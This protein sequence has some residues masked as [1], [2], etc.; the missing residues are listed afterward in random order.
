MDYR[1]LGRTG[2]EVSPLCLGTMMFGA[3]GNTD[4]DDSIRVIH[5]ALDAGINFIDCA[6]V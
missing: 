3:W 4:V 5:H 6:D 1:L 2:V